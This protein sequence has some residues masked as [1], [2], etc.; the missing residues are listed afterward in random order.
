MIISFTVVGAP[1]GKQR[2]RFG[3]GGN[4]YTPEKTG[5]HEKLIAWA[6][7]QQCGNFRFLDKTPLDMRIIAYF[8]IPKRATKAAR[9]KMLSGEIRPTVTPDWDNIGKLVADA[10]NDIAYDDD[11]CIVDAQVRKFYSTDPRTVII[12]Q[13]AQEMEA[14]KYDGTNTRKGN[15]SSVR[16]DTPVDER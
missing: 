7:R 4:T 2:P 1:F 14:R 12:L 8:R 9:E 15:G 10:L 3:K 5:D 11:K 6:Y 16:A 13:E